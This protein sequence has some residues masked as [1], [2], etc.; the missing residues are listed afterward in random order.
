MR[1]LA[2]SCCRSAQRFFHA[3]L[4]AGFHFFHVLESAGWSL[5]VRSS[6]C[7]W[8]HQSLVNQRPD[9]LAHRHSHYIAVDVQIENHDRQMI[10]PAHGD[11]GGIHHPQDCASAHRSSRFPG[12]RT[13]SACCQR[14]FV[15]DAVDA[16][17]L[18]DHLGLDLQAAQRR[19]RV[20]RKIGIRSSRRE[21]HDRALF[22]DAG[23]PGAGCKVR[24]PRCIS[25]ARHDARAEHPAFQARPAS[26]SALITVASMP[27]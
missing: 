16:R 20:G 21:N 9:R 1:M 15:V 17:G 8:F 2:I 7:S 23:W 14:I 22:P 26:A 25:I 27:M 13:A 5:V 18:G 11:R 12:T 6:S 4:G 19:R 3:R 24:P 10:V